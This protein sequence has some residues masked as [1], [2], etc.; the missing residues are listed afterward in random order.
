MLNI[1][2][3]GAGGWGKNLV[4]VFGQLDGCRLKTVCDRNEQILEAQRKALPGVYCTPRFE[5]VLEDEDIQAVV[6]SVDAP[7]HFALA[8]GALLA[9]KHVF[10][11]KP[12]TLDEAHARE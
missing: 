3:V 2:V 6:V 7:S 1:A 5:D 9:G 11:E 10:V 8:R 4:R 12:L